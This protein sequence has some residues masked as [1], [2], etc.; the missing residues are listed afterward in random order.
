[1]KEYNQKEKDKKLINRWYDSYFYRNI[2][3][4]IDTAIKLHAEYPLTNLYLE[5]KKNYCIECG[6]ELKTD[7]KLCWACEKGI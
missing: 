1:M 5:A 7:D 3:P 2:D 6:I 4:I